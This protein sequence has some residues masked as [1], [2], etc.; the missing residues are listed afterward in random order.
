MRIGTLVYADALRLSQNQSYVFK[1]SLFCYK[2]RTCAVQFQYCSARF[3]YCSCAYTCI[4][5]G[6]EHGREL[7][8]A[9]LH[10]KKTRK[11]EDWVTYAEVLKKPR[12][13]IKHKWRSNN[14]SP[15]VCWR[16]VLSIFLMHWV[17]PQWSRQTI[18][19]WFDE[20]GMQAPYNPPSAM[21]S[22]S[23]STVHS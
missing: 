5:Q 10:S 11:E 18:G 20:V 12:G 17:T 21:A 15:K 16:N 3:R 22:W 8:L 7:Y 1:W 9:E 2:F 13:V 4:L 6:A 23:G 14:S 19:I